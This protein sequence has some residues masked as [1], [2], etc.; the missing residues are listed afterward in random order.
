MRAIP[1]LLAI[2]A[3]PALADTLPAYCGGVGA[4][5][6]TP[7][8]VTIPAVVLNLG[9]VITV[10]NA[11]VAVNG[12]TSSVKA[13]MANPGPDGISLQEA[14]I[15][16]NN[17]PGTWNIQFAPALKGSTI[18]VDS[19]PNLPGLSSLSGGNVTIN[20]DIDGDGQPDIT[21]TSLSGTNTGFLVLSGGNTL[22][23]LALQGCGICVEI[24]RPAGATGATFSINTIGNLVM[25]NIRNTGI[26]FTPD[27]VSPALTTGNTWD[28]LLITGNTITGSVSGPVLGIALGLS[29]AGDTLQHTTIANNNIV[30]PMPGAGGIAMNIGSG[31]GATG[32]RAL[33]TLI[34]NNAIS[35]ALPQFG[36]R[37]ATGVGSA[38]ANLIDGVQIISNQ[39]SVTGQNPSSSPHLLGIDVVSGDAASDDGYPSL[40]P[41]QYSENNI[42]RNI[43]ILSNTLNLADGVGI[44]AQAACCGNG[45][46]TIG[47]LSILGNT[48]TGN[49]QINGA[50]SGGYFSRTSTGN[51]LSNVLIQA[52]SILNTTLPG[53]PNF[54]LDESI[55][56]AGIQVWAGWEEPGNSVNGIS[57]A[58]NDVNTPFL[59]IEIIGGLGMTQGPGDPLFPADNNVVSAA[60][61]FCN[62]VDQAPTL[63]VTPS[64]GI[65]GITVAAGAGGN[66]ASGNQVQVGVED[67]LVAGVLGDASLFANLESGASGNTIS[68]TQISGPANG[69]Q[70]TAAGVV[71]AASF[72]QRALAPGSLVSL[73]GLNLAP[74]PIVQFGGISAPIIFAS[75]SQ[76]NLQVPWEL[77]GQSTSS[78]TVTVNS[79]TSAAQVVS[80]GVADPGVFS[81]G[82][83]EGGQG[84][85]V[86]LAGIL[87]DANSP[88]HAGDYL[89]IYANGL[90]PVSNTPQTGA[91]AVLSPLSTLIGNPAVTIGGVPAPV[92]WAG[93]A[94]GFIGLYQVNVQVPQGIAAGDGAPVVLSTGATASNTVTISVR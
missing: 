47:N 46:N 84:A 83:P 19:G 54:T 37:L 1:F 3:L 64:S 45:N 28:H 18:V 17:D 48:I 27:H 29:M 63:G 75:S 24:Q 51:T 57:I 71:N 81:M 16:T 39:V 68:I 32:N 91:V 90:G 30:L 79:I 56:D 36:V 34:A 11:T 58:N 5:S 40:R 77:Q 22:Y 6:Y 78:V 67:N 43:G 72:Q 55:G 2:G 41:I 73:F 62:Q 14:I 94:P 65:K 44:E 15:A 80:V 50:A 60:Q 31:L 85:I 82:A 86:N 88:A 25:T 70:F 38:S 93:L 66:A 89:E 87:V 4:K 59:G 53:N 8:A 12:D 9:T 49:V 74:S 35:G 23:G 21:L 10:T 42:A 92:S 33:D 61:V 13:L 76:V 26:D 69:P 20:G 7:P 52:N